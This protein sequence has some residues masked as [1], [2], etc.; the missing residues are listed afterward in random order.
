METRTDTLCDILSSFDGDVIPTE[1]KNRF[2]DY[3]SPELS[4]VA[5]RG[6]VRG[7]L[8][9]TIYHLACR[10]DAFYRRLQEVVPADVRATQ[11]YQTQNARAQSALRRLSRYAETGPSAQQASDR[12]IDVPECARQLRYIVH[13]VYEDRNTRKAV[14]PLGLLVLRRLAEILARLVVQVVRWDRDIY[15]RASWDRDQPLNEQPRERNLFTYLI[16][17]PPVDSALPHWMRDKFVIDRLRGFPYSEWSHL[18]EL[19]TTIK[20]GIEEM[21]MDS[22]P[23]SF[24]YVATIDDMIQDYTATVYEPSSSSAQPRRA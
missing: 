7:S 5:D 24:G 21:D 16:G 17:D 1:F 8:P 14:A 3:P 10:D 19:F 13:S 20:D 15:E 23:G 9:A 18:L 6:L 2:V 4:P 12:N 22:V 11:Y